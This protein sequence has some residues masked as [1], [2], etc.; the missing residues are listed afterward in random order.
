[1]NPTFLTLD[2]VLAVHEDQIARYGGAAGVRDLGLLRSALAQPQ[3]TFGGQFLHHDLIAM[4]AAYFFYLVQNHAFVDE[5]KRVGTVAAM[6]FLELNGLELNAPDEQLES[7]VLN[8]AQGLAD[9]AAIEAFL[10]QHV[11]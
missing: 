11:S 6:V 2:E 5:N 1:M 8:V 10:R 4:A 3:A 9:T 7:I